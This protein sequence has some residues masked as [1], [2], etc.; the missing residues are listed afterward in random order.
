MQIKV[1]GIVAAV[2]GTGILSLGLAVAGALATDLKY[3]GE[4]MG[5]RERWNDNDD[6]VI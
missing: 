1:I 2:I 3:A 5:N 4:D 6:R